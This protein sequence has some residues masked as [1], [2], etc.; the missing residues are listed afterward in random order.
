MNDASK[1]AEL[2]TKY[3]IACRT[4]DRL[5]LERDTAQT[6]ART[7]RRSLATMLETHEHLRRLC[8][9][10]GQALVD[11]YYEQQD[12]LKV[13]KV[14]PIISRYHVHPMPVGPTSTIRYREQDGKHS[15]GTSFG[16]TSW[17]KDKPDHVHTVNLGTGEGAT[18]KPMER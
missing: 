10:G 13:Q 5:R 2:K 1:L 8:I 4:V 15:H 12:T 6:E 16:F 9:E 17:E 18:G 3:S 7:A 14:A 11:W